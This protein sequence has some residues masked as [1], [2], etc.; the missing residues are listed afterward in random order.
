MLLKV[1][2]HFCAIRE[3]LEK[4]FLQVVWVQ[5][6]LRQIVITTFAVRCSSR[7]HTLNSAQQGHITHS[8]LVPLLGEEPLE[9]G[10]P[11]VT[12]WCCRRER[13]SNPLFVERVYEELD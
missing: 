8:V 11:F 9:L 3:E 4:A 6:C 7:S 10:N 1:N 5:S 13:R 12:L 2:K